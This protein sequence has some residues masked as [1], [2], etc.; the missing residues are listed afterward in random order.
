MRRTRQRLK[1]RPPLDLVDI[2]LQHMDA[3]PCAALG[4]LGDAYERL[5]KRIPRTNPRRSHAL[6]NMWDF[7][8]RDLNKKDGDDRLRHPDVSQTPVRS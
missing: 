6:V 1:R 4:V 5:V 2:A 3:D 7:L 8:D